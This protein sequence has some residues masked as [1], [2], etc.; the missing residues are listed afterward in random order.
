MSEPNRDS[1]VRLSRGFVA[2]QWADKSLVSGEAFDFELNAVGQM[3][4]FSLE[5][6]LQELGP[7]SDEDWKTLMGLAI[8]FA[9]QRKQNGGISP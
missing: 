5:T 3:R 2:A 4:L 8:V 1:L 9:T 6:I 7:M